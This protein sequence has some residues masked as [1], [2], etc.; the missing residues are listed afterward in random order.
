MTAKV[1][2]FIKKNYYF[3]TKIRTST[4]RILKNR[5]NGTGNRR[6]RVLPG[7]KKYPSDNYRGIMFP[8]PPAGSLAVYVFFIIN[9]QRICDIAPFFITFA[10]KIQENKYV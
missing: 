1:Y 2:I 4:L 7:L 5:Q 8:N 10:P 6:N 3:G 9:T